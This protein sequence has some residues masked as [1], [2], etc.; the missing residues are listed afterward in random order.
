[1][2]GAEGDHEESFEKKVEEEVAVTGTHE[3][4]PE[5]RS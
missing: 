1:M 5:T 3:A 4:I 2:H